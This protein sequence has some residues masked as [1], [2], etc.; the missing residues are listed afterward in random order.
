[1]LTET[2]YQRWK[3]LC[4]V[5]LKKSFSLSRGGKV[6]SGVMKRPFLAPFQPGSA[7]LRFPSGNIQYTWFCPVHYWAGLANLHF[8][9]HTTDSIRFLSGISTGVLVVLKEFTIFFHWLHYHYRTVSIQYIHFTTTWSLKYNNQIM[10]AIFFS[11]FY[12]SFLSVLKFSRG[13]SHCVTVG[14]W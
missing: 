9:T 8:K 13:T 1:M 7:Y 2:Q 4:H 5:E 14:E 11:Q 10:P 12:L 3:I 6:D